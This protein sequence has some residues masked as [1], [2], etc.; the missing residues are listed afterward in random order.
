MQGIEEK[1]RIQVAL[2]SIDNAKD[3]SEAAL[4][5]EAF[6]IYLWNHRH[7]GKMKTEELVA[8]ITAAE[9]RCRQRDKRD[10]NGSVTQDLI[11][12]VLTI[13]TD[14]EEALKVRL[15]THGSYKEQYAVKIPLS[16]VGDSTYYVVIKTLADAVR[17]NIEKGT[18]WIYVVYRMESYVN[19]G[20]VPIFEVLLRGEPKA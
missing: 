13:Q 20:T 16:G 10:N 11:N 18:A 4:A 1:D 7:D 14:I 6:M 15:K 9:S 2:Q 12:K 5:F 3:A 19:L 8:W 17:K